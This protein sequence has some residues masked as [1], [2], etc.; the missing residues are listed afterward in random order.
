MTRKLYQSAVIALACLFTGC[1][2]T[3]GTLKKLPIPFV[4]ASKTQ[5]LRTQ[6]E[7]DS[8]PTAKQAGL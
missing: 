4:G 3:P 7:A 8:F 2:A 6:V 5:L 1:T